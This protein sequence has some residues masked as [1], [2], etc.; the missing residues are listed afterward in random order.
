[1]LIDLGAPAKAAHRGIAVGQSQ[2][3]AI[4]HHHVIVKFIAEIVVE[5]D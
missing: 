3:S 4:F 2:L 5:L 1:M